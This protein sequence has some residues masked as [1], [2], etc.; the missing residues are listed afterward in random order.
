MAEHDAAAAAAYAK[1]FEQKEISVLEEAQELVYGVRQ[2]D[3]GHPAVNWSRT[4]TLFSAILGV[5]VTAEQAA[6]CM[7]AV[8]LARQVHKPSR[9]NLVDIAGYAGVVELIANPFRR[10]T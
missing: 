4:A 6:L 10:G 7:I 8:K 5:T 3:Y 2:Q 9:D 1:A